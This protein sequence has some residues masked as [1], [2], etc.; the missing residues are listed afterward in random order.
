[1]FLDIHSHSMS[2]DAN[3]KKVFNLD[4]TE[5]TLD[6]DLEHFFEGNESVSIGIHPWSV[7]EEMF[8]EQIGC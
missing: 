2:S 5:N 4:I 8:F 3:I 1:M 6:E 7:S